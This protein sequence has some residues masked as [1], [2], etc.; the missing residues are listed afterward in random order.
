[1]KQTLLIL[2]LVL[3]SINL[4]HAQKRTTI[5]GD[6]WV[7]IVVSADETTREIKLR[8]PDASKNDT[9]TGFLEEGYKVKLKD[10]SWRF[11]QMSEVKPGERIRV[12]YKSKTRDVGGQKVKAYNIHRLDFMGLDKY[13]ML[14]EALNVPPATPVVVNDGAKVPA[15]N[16]L[17]LFLSI[18]QP[19]LQKYLIGW[20]T[21]WNKDAK[22]RRID[23]VTELT[24]SD[25]SIVSFWGRDDLVTLFPA[26]IGY[27][28][29]DVEEMYPASIYLVTRDNDTVKVIWEKFVMMPREEFEGK[30]KLDK[31]IEKMLKAPK[32]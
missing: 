15:A 31:D 27:G 4:A 9:F 12:F 29:G 5:L 7:G 20:V 11:L 2:L 25:A 6:A 13:D 8:H 24:N 21:E 16:P 10:G 26:L 28:S 30:L 14:R 19:N 23:L 1:M 18:Q 22:N 3:V 32:K 17:R